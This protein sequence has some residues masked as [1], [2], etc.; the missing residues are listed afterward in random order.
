MSE[1]V[2]A[3]PQPV[4]EFRGGRALVTEDALL[5]DLGGDDFTMDA[6]SGAPESVN[7][8][9]TGVSATPDAMLA[10]AAPEPDPTVEDAVDAAAAEALAKPAEPEPEPLLGTKGTREDPLTLKDLPE[11]KWLKVKVDGEL[12]LVNLR[13]A[14]E[15]SY[16]RP[17][18]F[19][20][21]LSKANRAKTEAESIARDAVE[22]QT[23]FRQGFDM[24]I[25]DPA[26]VFGMMLDQH[27]DVLEQVAIKYA[28]L[29]KSET[30][31]PTLRQQ[32]IFGAQQR[33]I[34]E[35]RQRTQQERQQW[36]AQR[37]QTE[38]RDAA[39]REL[40]PGYEAGIK[41][42]GFPTVTQELRTHIHAFLQVARGQNSGRPLT[43]ADVRDAVVRA[44]RYLGIAPAA[45]AAAPARAAAAP[46]RAPAPAARPRPAPAQMATPTR[47]QPSS[48]GSRWDGVPQS[49]RFNNLDYFL[50]D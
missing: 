24:W 21:L 7:A 40:K 30:E 3:T 12:Q 22:H 39:M 17:Q 2:P 43:P 11:D 26:K 9:E 47:P 19:D 45:P 37:A 46:A 48:N 16:L 38:A 5:G 1:V 13:E 25:R 41:E 15:G 18:A 34:A 32:R 36:E 29:R 35:D 44:G 8:G 50:E 6:P 49:H 31:N 27:E 20:R 10:E 33:K 14:L 23:R 28:E 4:S 42:L